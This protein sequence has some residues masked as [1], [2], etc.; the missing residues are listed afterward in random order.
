MKIERKSALKSVPVHFICIWKLTNREEEAQNK[1]ITNWIA[2]LMN[3][4][5]KEEEEEAMIQCEIVYDECI[6]IDCSN[7]K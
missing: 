2:I 6:V 1:Q 7:G 5:E 4:G 3:D